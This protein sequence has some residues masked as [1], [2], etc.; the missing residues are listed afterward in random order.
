V[1]ITL[2][3]HPPPTLLFSFAVG[4]ECQPRRLQFCGLE[5]QA[6]EPVLVLKCDFI[7]RR[8][9]EMEALGVKGF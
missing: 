2:V 3:L 7:G 1:L 6:H 4:N 8:Q 9:R 5:T